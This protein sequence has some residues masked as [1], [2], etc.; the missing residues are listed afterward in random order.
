MNARLPARLRSLWSRARVPIVVAVLSAIYYASFYRCALNL[1]DEGFV[2][3]AALRVTQGQTPGADFHGY[4][5]GRAYL[6]AGL[7]KLLGT[8]IGVERW[9]WI[10]MRMATGALLWLLARR[11]VGPGYAAVVVFLA[12]VAPGPWHKTPLVLGT[13]LVLWLLHHLLTTRDLRAAFF[14]GAGSGAVLLLREEIGLLGLGAAGTMAIGLAWRGGWIVMIRSAI[15]VAAG[16]A[17]PLLLVAVPLVVSGRLG[18]VLEFHLSE[19]LRLIFGGPTCPVP[20]QSHEGVPIVGALAVWPAFLVLAALLDG[21]GRRSVDGS[22]LLLCGGALFGLVVIR[23]NPDL[24]H[25]LQTAPVQHLLTL[26][27]LERW[28]RSRIDEQPL[29]KG[30]RLAGAGAYVGL[31]LLAIVL[32]GRGDPYYTGSALMLSERSHSVQVLDGVARASEG[33]AYVTQEVVRTVQQHVERNAPI[34]VYPYAPMFYLLARGTNPTG[35]DG[36][37]PHLLADEEFGRGLVSDLEAS[38][39]RVMVED[40]GMLDAPAYCGSFCDL[41]PDLCAFREQFEEVARFGPYAVVVR[42]EPPSSHSRRP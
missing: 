6:L 9:M 27:L 23:S 35:Y 28:T 20:V 41:A 4:A 30:V 12:V 22:I 39:V 26:A 3:Q 25:L 38:G 1:S 18:D 7:F 16:A 21:I 2:L 34:F 31:V 40:V 42:Q 10:G 36:I 15:S 32:H 17:V 29:F 19:Q 24:S 14:A 33:R 13:V 37:F 5:P 11:F 8:S